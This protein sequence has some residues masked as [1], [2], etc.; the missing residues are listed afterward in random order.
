MVACELQTNI[1]ARID[2]TAVQCPYCTVCHLTWYSIRTHVFIFVISNYDVIWFSDDILICSNL[3]FICRL[4][5][6]SR[7]YRM[8][9]T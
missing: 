3:F 2:R 7:I 5:T 1:K 4:I 6:G 9:M 8:C